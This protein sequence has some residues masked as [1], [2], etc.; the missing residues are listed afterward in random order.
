VELIR[1]IEENFERSEVQVVLLGGAE[2]TERNEKLR[3]LSLTKNVIVSESTKGLRDGILSVQAC[4][5]VISGDSLGMHL[6]IALRKYTIAWFGPTC[7]H[8]IDLFQKGSK[9]K[10]Y[11]SCSPCWKRS[12][13]HERMC[14]DHVNIS[15]FTQ[16]LE[17][18]ISFISI[19][20]PLTIQNEIDL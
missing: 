15:D 8:E 9:I 19:V 2:D 20:P 17:E 14:F 1:A 11:L 12:C 10:T 13:D 6:A 4:D 16:A 3:L 5:I 18:G 7:D